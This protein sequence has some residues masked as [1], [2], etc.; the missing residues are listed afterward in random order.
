M[1]E[2]VG[3]DVRDA[4]SAAQEAVCGFIRRRF[5]RKSTRPAFSIAPGGKAGN[6]HLI[7]FVEVV[8]RSK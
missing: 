3:D 6:G 8:G 5:W 4:F 1:G 7:V 2:L